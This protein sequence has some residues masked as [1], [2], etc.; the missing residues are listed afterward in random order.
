[1]QGVSARPAHLVVETVV[2]EAR[3]VSSSVFGLERSHLLVNYGSSLSI[4]AV[5]NNHALEC[6]AR[7]EPEG[8]ATI[9]YACA[10]QHS[11][12][13]LIFCLFSDG[14]N[15]LLALAEDGVLYDYYS[16]RLSLPS[17]ADLSNITC[18]YDE[19]R[20]AVVIFVPV[21]PEQHLEHSNG[22]RLLVVTE[23]PRP[24]VWLVRFSFDFFPKMHTK[25]DA[26]EWP[27]DWCPSMVTFVRTKT[28]WSFACVGPPGIKTFAIKLGERDSL[29]EFRE[30]KL[31][32]S[33]PGPVSDL[34]FLEGTA[35]LLSAGADLCLFAGSKLLLA[36]RFDSSVTRIRLFPLCGGS[37]FIAA[38]SD[39]T[40]HLIA[41]SLVPGQESLK[42][43]P[44]GQTHAG[45]S[46]AVSVS[47]IATVA[48]KQ[49][50]CHLIFIGCA[51]GDS[52]V[53]F[54]IPS[55]PKRRLHII[56]TTG[57]SLAPISGLAQGPKGIILV[58]FGK[59]ASSGV[60]SLSRTFRYRS[61]V[62]FPLEKPLA[63]FL[64][65]ANKAI[66]MSAEGQARVVRLERSA[67]S[68]EVKLIEE[69]QSG[70]ALTNL[71]PSVAIWPATMSGR[72]VLFRVAA[73]GTLEIRNAQDFS[74]ICSVAT[75]EQALSAGA[76][77]HYDTGTSVFV[78]SG[79]GL[80]YR[81]DVDPALLKMQHVGSAPMPDGFSAQLDQLVTI[82]PQNLLFA[83][84]NG[85]L[86]GCS[87]GTAWGAIAR[88][89]LQGHRV[90]AIA[91]RQS[92][93]GPFTNVA[94]LTYATDTNSVR[95]YYLVLFP[96]THTAVELPYPD[97]RV[98]LFS[99]R[100][101]V[102]S[103]IRNG[104]LRFSCDSNFLQI[105]TVQFAGGA[106][107]SASQTMEGLWMGVR[108]ECDF[109]PL[110]SF[111]DAT[112]S[113]GQIVTILSSPHDGMALSWG[114]QVG[115]TT[116]L[117]Y[118]HSST[119]L[120]VDYIPDL[121]LCVALDVKG[122]IVCFDP[123]QSGKGPMKAESSYNVGPDRLVSDMR[124]FTT[125]DGT[126]LLALALM[127][128][129]EM[130]TSSTNTSRMVYFQRSV[131]FL[132]F[133]R[134]PN[135]ELSIGQSPAHHSINLGGIGSCLVRLAP[136]PF[137]EG[138]IAIAFDS[139]LQVVKFQEGSTDSVRVW[140]TSLA[141][142]ISSNDICTHISV[143]GNYLTLLHMYGSIAVL[144]GNEE[145]EFSLHRQ[146]I[147]AGRNDGPAPVFLAADVMLAAGKDG[148]TVM[149][150]SQQIH[151]AE[152]YHL[153]VHGLLSSSM[154][155]PLTDV[156]V[157]GTTAG[158]IV[159][160]RSVSKAV[161]LESGQSDSVF[162]DG[163]KWRKTPGKETS[164]QLVFF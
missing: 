130:E 54:V 93:T 55:N 87:F 114:G 78:L 70:N 73:S 67:A 90:L 57:L 92:S 115:H 69:A 25:I 103:P 85:I 120:F 148:L 66:I 71:G 132:R 15:K 51:T 89:V 119:L 155:N 13:G 56:G 53:A 91:S 153:P 7:M 32:I 121:C 162:L 27:N 12:A 52:S 79:A 22:K 49:G 30:L 26:V 40:L 100:V 60:A 16:K 82:G 37:Q 123:S 99:E 149:T 163:A 160:L 21:M 136:L 65:G 125:R 143:S 88:R 17:S 34:L 101:D 133:K 117:L 41:V 58:S 113:N 161:W 43:L 9:L 146:G 5:A 24:L 122:Q 110:V 95:S 144:A 127:P 81:Y 86:Y 83:I 72:H 62:R 36:L 29:P 98:F 44:L 151:L 31:S 145:G 3:V 38:L 64:I 135:G 154:H 141:A 152:A 4:F 159:V 116:R 2:S 158:Q 46:P 131:V 112:S 18:A 124:R 28:T 35:S 118:R 84:G 128:K 74:V 102:S 96:Y 10:V 50:P 11:K 75:C 129:V 33:P 97:S 6:V 105:V 108:T 77:T 157:F 39:G 68:S 104:T 59:D 142:D 42:S 1:M 63:A 140:A 150:Q 47:H 111:N 48:F 19:N 164:E 23:T 139:F 156:A 109:V 80:I 20:C 137:L 107:Y 94:L 147:L 126:N 45:S 8:G 134:L 14:T 106:V 76:D 61:M 138:G